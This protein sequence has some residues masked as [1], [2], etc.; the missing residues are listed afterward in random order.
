MPRRELGCSLRRLLLND[1]GSVPAG[2]RISRCLPVQAD[3]NSSPCTRSILFPH[4]QHYV[5][6]AFRGSGFRLG[7]GI[8]P[9]LFRTDR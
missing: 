5:N 9:L 3:A 7:C 4:K 8:R 1:L 2:A 6:L